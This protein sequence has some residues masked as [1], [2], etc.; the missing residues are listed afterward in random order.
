MRGWYTMKLGAKLY[1]DK[2]VLEAA[3]ERISLL[4]DD[5]ENVVVSVSGGKDSTVLLDL[6]RREA[7]RRGRVVHAFFLDQEAEYQSTIDQIRYL[8]TLPGVVP[9]WYQVPI[10]MTNATSLR[11]PFLNAWWPGEKWMHDKDPLAIHEINGPY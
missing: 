2:N 1:L 3:Q 7:Q 11:V 8:M 9:H 10:R 5:F 4:F 6:C